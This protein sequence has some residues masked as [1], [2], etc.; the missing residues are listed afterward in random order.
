MTLRG[1]V[2][3][4]GQWLSVVMLVALA[5]GATLAIA[6]NWP[7]LLFV[8]VL[9]ALLTV[10]VMARPVPVRA[11]VATFPRHAT[12]QMTVV[13]PQGESHQAIVVH[14]PHAD[15]DLQLVLTSRGYALVDDDGLIRHQL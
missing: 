10:G 13:S 9:L 3:G 1:F 12:E 6:M 14:L 4:P 8:S 2:V 15:D 5:A 7:V 11:R